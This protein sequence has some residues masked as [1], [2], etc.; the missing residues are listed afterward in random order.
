MVDSDSNQASWIEVQSRIQG[1]PDREHWNRWREAVMPI[2]QRAADAEF[3]SLFRAGTSMDHIIFSTLDHDGLRDEPRVTLDVRFNWKV[4]ISYTTHNIHFRSPNQFEE[5][6]PSS[7]FPV[8]TRY[9]Q[10]LWEETIPE[11]IPELLRL[12]KNYEI[13][14]QT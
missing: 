14:P 8:F 9:L 6:D 1:Y 10:H 13:S 11:P 5:I 2:L 3:D 7:A 12:R 4:R